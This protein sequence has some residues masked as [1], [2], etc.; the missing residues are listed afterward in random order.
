MADHSPVPWYLERDMDEEDAPLLLS[1]V[2]DF[3][4]VAKIRGR[5]GPERDMANALFIVRACNAHDELLAALE[6][7]VA[8]TNLH[9]L[10]PATLAQ[11]RAAIAKAKG[12]MP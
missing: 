1:P 10:L 8:I 5:G 9:G 12:E 7:F 6:A 4:T 11:A 3:P 2:P